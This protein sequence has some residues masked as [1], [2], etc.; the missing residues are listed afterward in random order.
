MRLLHN[1]F[2]ELCRGFLGKKVK[3]LFTSTVLLGDV[4][5]MVDFALIPQFANLLRRNIRQNPEFGEQ[6]LGAQKFITALGDA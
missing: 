1:V 2:T 4:M 6:G 3:T 5:D